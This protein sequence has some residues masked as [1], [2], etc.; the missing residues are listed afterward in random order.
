M[1]L[2]PDIT[3]DELKVFLQETDEQIELLDE[4]IIR[5]EK[6]GDDPELLQE[7]FRAA[8][9][10]KGSSAMVGHQRMAELTHTMENLLDKLRNRT[11]SVSTELIDALLYSLD[12]LKVLKEEITSS[13]DSDLDINPVVAR[14]KDM[15]EDEI[16]SVAITENVLTLDQ[17]AR[18]DIQAALAKGQ[19]VYR[20]TASI[21]RGSE[22]VAVRCLQILNELLRMGEVIASA[23]TAEDIEEEKVGFNIELI[24]ASSEDKDTIQGVVVS[25]AEIAD[26]KIVSCDLEEDTESS[27]KT[28]LAQQKGTDQR[29]DV[30]GKSSQDA[31]KLTN[32]ESTQT[33]QS[34]RIDV[35]VLDNL[36]NIVEELV[37]D[38]SRI[39]RV[40]RMLQSRYTDD[41]LIQELGETSDH[42]IQVI[43]ELQE[44]IMKVRMVPIGIVFSRFPRLVRDL[45]QTQKKKLDF[46]I[47]GEETELDRSI[48]E[49]IRDPLIHL[50]RNAVDH[51]IESPEERRAIS[52][53]ETAVI[54][55]TAC[56]E[57]GHIVITVDDDGKG[58]DAT[59]VVESSVKKGLI[60]AEE[61]ENLSESGA[62]NLIFMAGM[63]TAEKATEVSGRGVGLDIVRANVESLSGSISLDTKLGLGSKFAIRL[64]LT[65][66][67]VQGLL[68][69][70]DGVL[71]VMP[72]VS[73][74][75]TLM[76]EPSEIQ[77]IRGREIIRVRGEII[78]IL[79][80]NEIL[81]SEITG[82]E[83]EEKK[84]I[85][86]VKADNNL[87]GVVVDALMERQEVVVKSLGEYLG[88]IT[89]IAGATILGDGKV[90][91]I[92]DVGSL[93][94][95]SIQKS[96]SNRGQEIGTI[97]TLNLTAA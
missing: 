22:W 78:P 25:V 37:I 39:S 64:P 11:L 50:L 7:I 95:M 65:V 36:M 97:N 62:I 26:V 70:S 68:I 30:T 59:K 21:E 18:E 3:A 17:D 42:I 5:L 1:N 2:D 83:N 23:P 8:H 86:I 90:A 27:E 28:N 55:L 24:L 73:L 82:T 4:D 71:Y 9:T 58:I 79:R 40:G 75:E 63:S 81:D 51:G 29:L 80:L 47:E 44:N 33:L 49:Q 16:S 34:V 14:L 88:E 72:L 74:M 15:T 91:L 60:T 6:E 35:Q 67:I 84:L 46:I 19:N 61:A 53:S 66:A 41:G 12:A 87:L 20:I 13:E 48:I 32:Q 38:R 43:N 77:T 56:H 85:V 31:K 10:L 54:R 92:L 94:K 52:K 93:V 57:Q 76:V 96:T 45:A 69:S 89:G